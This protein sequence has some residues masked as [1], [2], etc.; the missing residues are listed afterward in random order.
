MSATNSL[1]KEG[2]VIEKLDRVGSLLSEGHAIEH[3][4]GRFDSD[5]SAKNEYAKVSSRDAD[6]TLAF[7]EEFD[8]QVPAITAE[9]EKRLSRKVTWIV[10]SLAALINLI[11]YSDKATA[12][13]SSILGLFEEV[14]VTQNQ[15]NNANSLFYAGFIVGQFNLIFVQKYPLK[16]V[17]ST[18]TTLWTVVIFLHC[19]CTN[20]KGFYALRFFLGFVESIALPCLNTTMAQFLTAD[21]KAAS[22]PMFYSTC[23]GVTIPVGFIAYGV[24]NITSTTVSLWKIFMMI[25]GGCTLLLT[26]L[27]IFVYP[28]NPTDAVFLSTEEKVWVIRRVQ[29]TTGS[30]IEQKVLKKH[31]VKE[32][33]RDP[34]SWLFGAFFLLQQL[35]NNL[36]YQQNLLFVSIGNISNLDSTLVSVASGGFAVICCI[37]ATTFL[38]FFKNYTAFSVL[39]W[40]IPSFVGSIAMVS[41]PFDKH[42]ALLAMLCLA[43]PAFGVP[44]ILMFSWNSATC[45]GY[46]KKLT[47][48]AIVMFFFCVA[49][50]ISPQLW[51]EKDGPRYVP[52]W[53]VQIVLSFSIAPCLAIV[54][55]FILRKRN[56]QR[57]QNLA[58]E[59]KKFGLIEVNGENIKANIAMLDLTDHENKTFIYPL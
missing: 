41:I 9:Q 51:Q 39:F 17:V 48:N 29:Q 31:Q 13:Y 56:Q 50:L 54:I 30:S 6:V 42:I 36:P 45:S 38:L 44:W 53:I 46:T 25:I 55:W 26:I 58:A 57:A 27:V 20:Y 52:A 19:A 14:G 28:N 5:D 22:A 59:E 4:D 10:V 24:L 21:E 23:V 47:R 11:L 43:S 34:I 18:M 15:Y 7:L 49:N 1:E 37:L 33:L 32:A 40:T 35:A 8:G 2:E 3:Y 12:S 16:Y